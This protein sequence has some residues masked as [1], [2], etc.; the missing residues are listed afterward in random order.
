[1]EELGASLRDHFVHALLIK[2][3][4]LE[5]FLKQLHRIFSKFAKK[6]QETYQKWQSFV[7]VFNFQ[8]TIKF[9]D[10]IFGT[11]AN[12]ERKITSRKQKKRP[13]SLFK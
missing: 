5:V 11:V 4:F 1:M 9:V 10:D 7:T 6:L 13:A 2:A 3:L 12:T 8:S